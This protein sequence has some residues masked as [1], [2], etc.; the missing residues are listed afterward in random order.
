L[1]CG[2]T[3][4]PEMG[5]SARW[6]RQSGVRR[7]KASI[8]YPFARLAAV[9]LYV[10]CVGSPEAAPAP[11]GFRPG[12]SCPEATWRSGDAAD[13]KSA[14]PG[15]IPGV[16]SITFLASSITDLTNP[17]ALSRAAWRG[18]SF[19]DSARELGRAIYTL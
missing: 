17:L 5:K 19:T 9:H 8:F 15:S 11:F 1:D 16:A 10:R 13:C 6:N 12:G 2:R 7:P 18:D 3:A 14:Y 4:D